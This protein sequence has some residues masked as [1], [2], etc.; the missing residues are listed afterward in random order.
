MVS[1][2][3]G[4]NPVRTYPSPDKEID[5]IIVEN[6]GQSGVYRWVHI[7]SGKSYIGSSSKLSD[8]FRRYYRY[9]YLS[10]S[11]RGASCAQARH[12]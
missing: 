10:D 11:K 4:K 5:T 7:E 2:S 6:K 12:Y 3:A 1:T 9:S 8:R